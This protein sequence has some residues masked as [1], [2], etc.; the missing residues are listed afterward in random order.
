MENYFGI[1]YEFEYDVVLDRIDER[2]ACNRPGYICVS[3]G[4]ILNTVHRSAAYRQVVQDSMFCV[5]DS[6]YVPLYIKWIYKKEHQQLSGT[7]L[8]RLIVESQRYKM[9]FIG[10]DQNILTALQAQL[11]KLNPAVSDML[12]MELPFCHVADFDY[13]DIAARLNAYSPDIIFVSLGAPKQE[14]FMH[15]LLPHLERGVAIAV[16]AAFKFHAGIEERR[17][18]E[19]MVR[20]H[21]EW[22]FRIFQ[23]PKK[24]I[25]RCFWILRTTPGI[26][27]HEWN[28]VRHDRNAMSHS[29]KQ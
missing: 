23:D 24:Q 25:P 1:N 18:P 4:V 2:L 10:G 8:T 20:H 27:F 11:T 28:A 13:T 22:L 6:S 19:W 14:I 26:L 17:A 5:C 15:Y 12:F 16:G 29:R 7:E 9:A 21:M 3:D